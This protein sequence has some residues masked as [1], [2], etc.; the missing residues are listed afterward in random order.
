VNVISPAL[1]LLVSYKIGVHKKPGSFLAMAR[2]HFLGVDT[3]GTE[4]N[5]MSKPHSGNTY[6]I[7]SGT[8]LNELLVL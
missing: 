6:I 2:R 4:L 3:R 5:M 1:T 7:T 8:K